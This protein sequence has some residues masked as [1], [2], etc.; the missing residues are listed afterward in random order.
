MNKTYTT[1]DLASILN[2]SLPVA[3]KK[4][5][6]ELLKKDIEHTTQIILGKAVSAYKISENKMNELIN[7]VQINKQVYSKDKE[8]HEDY[9]ESTLESVNNATETLGNDYNSNNNHST[10]HFNPEI[11]L[12][13]MREYKNDLKSLYESLSLK[14]KQLYLL[15]DSESRTKREFNELSAEVKQLRSENEALKKENESLKNKKWWVLGK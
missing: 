1:K 7:E 12:D 14:D 11:L 6:R 13:V 5:Q 8:E 9:I 3:R 4:I 15:E 2:C 10:Q